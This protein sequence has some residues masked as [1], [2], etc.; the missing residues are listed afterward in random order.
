MPIAPTPSW[1]LFHAPTSNLIQNDG[2]VGGSSVTD[3]Y[4]KWGGLTLGQPA[5]GEYIEYN[6]NPGIDIVA[7][8]EYQLTFDYDNYNNSPTPPQLEIRVY[9]QEPTLGAGAPGLVFNTAMTPAGYGTIGTETLIATAEAPSLTSGT[10]IASE[11]GRMFIEITDLGSWNFPLKIDNFSLKEVISWSVTQPASLPGWYTP[12]NWTVDQNGSAVHQLASVTVGPTAGPGVYGSGIGTVGI[13]TQ[14]VGQLQQGKTYKLTMDVIAHSGDSLIVPGV[15]QDGPDAYVQ[16]I[17]STPGQFPCTG[18]AIWIQ[19]GNM[20]DIGIQQGAGGTATIDNVVLQEIYPIGGTVTSWNIHGD[21]SKI[22]WNED[23]FGSTTGS[24]KLD[25][26]TDSESISQ[27]INGID[28]NQGA[29]YQ[30]HVTIQNY[31]G[32]GRL[33]LELYNNDG[34]GFVSSPF[35]ANPTVPNGKHTISGIIGQ[36]TTNDV[37]KI[38]K[39]TIKVFSGEIFSGEIDNQTE[40]EGRVSSGVSLQLLKGG[41]DTVTFSEDVRGW[42]SFKS[43]VPEFGLSMVNNYY[44]F[45]EGRLWK[46][47]SNTTRNNFYGFQYE[48]SITPIL[49]LH[50]E[51]VKNFNTLS[52]EGSQSKIDRHLT[53]GDFYNLE[54]DVPGWYVINIKTDKQEGS[55]NEFIEKEGKWFNYIK[56]FQN[57]VDTSA[58]NFQGLGMVQSA[59]LTAGCTN[60]NATNFDPQATVDD[61][62]CIIPG[63]TIPTATN[64]DPTATIDNGSCGFAPGAFE[65]QIR[66]MTT[67]AANDGVARVVFAGTNTEATGF[68][69]AWSNGE[70]TSEVTGLT[71]GPI[72]LTLTDGQGNAHIVPH[73]GSVD[74]SNPFVTGAAVNGCTD[75]NATNFNW[76]ANTD[77]G[78]CTI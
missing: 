30:T 74:P 18:E 28:F 19:G 64:F 43:F 65:M 45:D 36:N 35:P 17:Q 1:Q 69:Y 20:V 66:H 29:V 59:Q 61:G 63:C 39:F 16:L 27:P 12:V 70:A 7:G 40:F 5:I 25:N 68:A 22:Y 67:P 26:A 10:N 13:L 53:D 54:Q 56:G 44:T 72:G 76:E 58:F 21:P 60:P 38:N 41:G 57:Q 6:Q 71:M 23:F 11:Y 31:S 15:A 9:G 2:N 47:H 73:P 33:V 52:Y 8:K 32:T 37:N 51:L 78:S 77:D 75:S 62:T 24:I 42:T 3:G 46:H 34:Q 50:P 49:N 55:L 14:D 48:S 4:I